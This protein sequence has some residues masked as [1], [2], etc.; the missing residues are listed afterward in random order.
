MLSLCGSGFAAGASFPDIEGHWAENE[1]TVLAAQNIIRGFPDGT[2]R[3]EQTISRAEFAVLTARL[4]GYKG[5]DE[6]APFD[7]LAGYWAEP[8]ISALTAAGIIKTAE[9]GGSFEPAKFITRAEMVRILVRAIDG[10]INCANDEDCAKAAMQYGVLKGYA[11]GSLGLDKSATRAEVFAMLL[12]AQTAK[13]GCDKNAEEKK[14]VSNVGGGSY[15]PPIPAAEISFALPE[16]A[17]VGESAVV[18]AAV[19]GTAGIDWKLLVNNAEAALPEDFKGIGGELAFPE[20]GTYTL[21][22]TAKNSAGRE[23][24]CTHTVNVYP[25][26]AL[27][28]E[29]PAAAHTDEAIEAVLSGE[30]YSLPVVWTLTKNGE[31]AELSECSEGTLSDTGGRIRFT[32]KGVYRL[33]A[34]ATDALGRA[35]SASADV[36][37]YPVG[38]IGVYLPEIFHTDD[39][40]NAAASFSNYDNSP[41]T[42]TL[43]HDGKTVSL[44]D[45]VS[46]GLTADGGSIR[47]TKA[48]SYSITAAY[49]DAGGRSYSYSQSFTVY[50]VPTL[51][52]AFDSTAHTDSAVTVKTTSTELDGL[53]V[54]WLVD[55]SCGIQNWDTYIDGAL[56]ND[57]GSI[58]FKH[59]GSYELIA[60]ATDATGRVFLFESD[61]KC[62]V[63]P[64]L[65]L[66]FSLPAVLHTDD[67][68]ELRTFGNN[69]I[70]PIAWSLTRDGK[71]VGVSDFIDGELNAYGG[72][73]RFKDGGVYT[74]TAAAADVLGRSFTASGSTT[75]LPVVDI[76][77]SAPAQ[78]HIGSAFTVSTGIQDS[79]A[80]AVRWTLTCDGQSAAYAGSLENGGGSISIDKVGSYVLTAAVTDAAG[81]AY[82]EN[83]SIEITNTAPDMPS[84][85]VEPTRVT[86]GGRFLVNISA[87]GTDPDGD[88]VTYEYDGASADGCYA[89]GQHTVK[90][91]AVDS[92]GLASDWVTKTFTVSNSAPTVSLS[93]APTR[94]VKDGRFLVTISASASDADGDDTTI[95]YDGFSSDDYYAVGTHTIRIRAKDACGTYSDWISKTFTIANSAPSTPVI[96]RSPDGNCVAPGTAVS[97]SASGADPDG[98]AVSYIWENRP[99]ASYVYGLGRQTVRVKAVD[100]TGAESPWAAIIFFVASS[101]NG[102]GMT[103]TG[104]D[105]TIMENGIAGATITSFTFTV[106]AVDGHNGSD[107][108]RVRG[109]NKNTGAWD[110]LA[111][112]TTNN[113]ITLTGRMESGVYT[114]L[115][116]YYYTNHNCMYNKSNITYS[117]DFYF[118]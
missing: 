16:T 56:G 28:L 11:D 38:Q 69:N 39:T 109:Y 5:S 4:F 72:S 45:Y 26:A 29:L 43:E 42:W 96:T 95:E 47:V 111:Y 44:S 75:V 79:D 82:F 12:R 117:V 70:L 53:T 3:P 93:A 118:E 1:I 87:A 63:Q 27:A 8:E 98:D 57:G 83:T 113:G 18:T 66:S 34:T 10:G 59:A 103:L 84:L 115:E 54:N 61:G 33:T 22:G 67:T 37:V 105:S 106:P 50:P 36:T 31:T 55:N 88:K 71:T 13:A 20:T 41:V 101:S 48:G 23:T 104:P 49:T 85:T 14:P 100:S 89:V 92:F 64:V 24:A 65:D 99:S 58:R 94:T 91:R 76:S 74:L 102:G 9:Y 21:T 81:R 46:G 114:R 35:F 32:G 15:T 30:R 6:P 2:V 52:F 62:V 25:V 77:M 97:I 90:V 112:Q 73:I 108:G 78:A 60:T 51:S 86:T 107:Y 7:D 110:Q 116:F 80:N 19:T 17:Y 40:V 68:V